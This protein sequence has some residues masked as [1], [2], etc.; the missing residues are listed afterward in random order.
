MSVKDFTKFLDFRR[1]VHELI[2]DQVIKIF[3]SYILCS[4]LF[5][6]L[7]GAF[8]AFK[9]IQ[10]KHS[11]LDIDFSIGSKSHFKYFFYAAIFL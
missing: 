6:I 2:Y 9:N 4:K 5:T 3:G 11:H 10:E 1:S 8:I 7:H